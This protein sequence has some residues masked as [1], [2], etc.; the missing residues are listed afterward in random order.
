MAKVSYCFA[1]ALAMAA[2][3]GVLIAPCAAQNSAEDFVNLHNAAREA[4]GVGPVSW[5]DNVAA[6]AQSW[7]AQ[8]AGNCALVHSGGNGGMY[9]ENLYWGPAGRDWSA[10]DAV[11]LW[12][13]EQRW[14]NYDSNSCSAPPNQSCGHYTQV[15]WRDSTTIGCA[16]VVCN[17][18]GII[19]SC[20]YSPPGNW[21]G[22]RPY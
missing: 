22:Q 15:V 13:A 3:A 1:L 11:G 18:G 9:G 12:V 17:N 21:P 4:V 19:I 16:R 6:F 20:N 7:A 10:S 14:Y 5:D 2:L 8:L